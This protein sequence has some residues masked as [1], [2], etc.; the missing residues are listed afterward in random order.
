MSRRQ[1]RTAVF[2]QIGLEQVARMRG[3]VG[4]AKLAG[5]ICWA[6]REQGVHHEL[7]RALPVAI[8]VG[9]LPGYFWAKC[10]ASSAEYMERIAYSM[11]LSVTLVPAAALL[12]AGLLD[13][14][15]TFLNGAVSV[16][17]VSVTGFVAY[18]WF[19]PAS[20]WV[21]GIIAGCTRTPTDSVPS[22]PVTR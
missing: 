3:L 13:S 16:S 19:G 20:G 5:C 7:I 22:A 4:P 12:Q 21:R 15:I 6:T 17:L 10:L 2:F 8:L 9:I 14:E 11:A 1:G 18:L